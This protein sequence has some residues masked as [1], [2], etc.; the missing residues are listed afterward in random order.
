MNATA[1]FPTPETIGCTARS[2]GP[3]RLPCQNPDPH[4]PGRG[5]VFVVGAP[6]RDEVA[7]SALDT[8]DD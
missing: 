3:A 4:T 7:D 2:H 1:T 5:C 6:Y 8:D